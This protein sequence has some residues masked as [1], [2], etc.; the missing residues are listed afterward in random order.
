[1]RS[2]FN[3]FLIGGAFGSVFGL[4]VFAVAL[5]SQGAQ[6]PVRAVTDPGVITTR[7]GITPAG[8]QSVFDGRVFGITFGA[9]WPTSSSCST[10]STPLAGT[11]AMAISG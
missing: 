8:V 2:R 4:S 1:M 9:S 3:S 6:P 10:T 5:L 11:P 7:Q